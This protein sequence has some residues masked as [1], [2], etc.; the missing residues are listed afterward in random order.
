[1]MVRESNRCDLHL[2]G[3]LSQRYYFWW[4]TTIASKYQSNELN[5]QGSTH[6]LIANKAS[7]TLPS[8]NG[9]PCAAL[10]A[11]L[12]ADQDM[13]FQSRFCMAL[14]KEFGV[15]FISLP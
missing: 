4:S 14:I 7:E 9:T 6:Q 8:Y 2:C 13:P 15:G 3:R 12:A 5:Y 10:P 1:M 11:S